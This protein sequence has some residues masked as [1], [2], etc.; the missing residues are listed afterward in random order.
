MAPC[1][2]IS[3]IGGAE[4]TYLPIPK[5]SLAEWLSELGH[6]HAVVQAWKSVCCIPALWN[7][8]YFYPPPVSQCI[9]KK[10]N[11]ILGF[12]SKAWL[13]LTQWH[14]SHSF[15]MCKFFGRSKWEWPS[16]FFLKKAFF[17][18]VIVLVLPL[19][20][21]RAIKKPSFQT[22]F[23]SL[24]CLWW[25]SLLFCLFFSLCSTAAFSF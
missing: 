15:K 5:G 16:I 1:E 21:L 23:F 9:F 12:K 24:A 20:V 6:C 18:F 13:I 11:S 17:N 3:I 19:S 25:H 14:I 8:T 4:G 10:P 22:F 2:P 7:S